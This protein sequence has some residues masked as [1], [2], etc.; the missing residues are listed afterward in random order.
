[1]D[2]GEQ[3]MD[4]IKYRL[5]SGDT[6]DVPAEWKSGEGAHDWAIRLPQTHLVELSASY[7]WIVADPEHAFSAKQEPI[8]LTRS[9]SYSLKYEGKAGA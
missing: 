3:V 2:L 6:T 4:I 8:S 9:S 5:R 1:M 7:W